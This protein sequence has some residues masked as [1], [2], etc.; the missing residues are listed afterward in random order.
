MK[1]FKPGDIV[2][3]DTEI[4]KKRWTLSEFELYWPN[5]L[6]KKLII[7]SDISNFG[8]DYVDIDHAVKN[9]FDIPCGSVYREWLKLDNLYKIRKKL[10]VT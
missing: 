2:V 3:I 10:G 9:E 7:K 4:V 5:L 1:Q 6:N 8:A